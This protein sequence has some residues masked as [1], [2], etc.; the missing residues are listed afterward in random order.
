MPKETKGDDVKDVINKLDRFARDPS[1]VRS[2]DDYQ[3]QQMFR[4]LKA[5]IVKSINSEQATVITTTTYASNPLG[6]AS[7]N[8]PVPPPTNPTASSA[9]PDYSISTTA[10][11]P[12]IYPTAPIDV[13][14]TAV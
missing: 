10:P 2:L 14:P 11:P 7:T 1:F 6:T 9:R 8:D 13:T 12:I 4:T 3:L 5:I